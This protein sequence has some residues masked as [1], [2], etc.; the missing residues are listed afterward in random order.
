MRP[1]PA[2]VADA[3]ISN[4][5]D[6]EACIQQRIQKNQ[7]MKYINPFFALRQMPD[8]K[9]PS[10][11]GRKTRHNRS[12]KKSSVLLSSAIAGLSMVMISNH[13]QGQAIDLGS[14]EDF[15]IISYAGLTST[16]FSIVNGDV[17]LNPIVSLVGFPPGVINGTVYANASAS[18]VNIARIARLDAGTAYTTLAG[19]TGGTVML[20]AQELNGLTLTP[21]I[22]KFSTSAQLANGGT[23]NLDTGGDPN[24]RFIFQIGSALT[25]GTGAQIVFTSGATSNIYWQV[26]SL[27]TIDT[28]STFSGNILAYASVNIGTGSTLTD[29]RAIAL[30]ESVTLQSNTLSAP[31]M[32][33]VPPPGSGTGAF[34]NGSG[35]NLW[36]GATNWSPT[37]LGVAQNALGPDSNV[38]FSIEPVSPTAPPQNQNTIL[39]ADTT[40]RTLTVNDTE[41]VTIG[42]PLVG[43]PTTLTISSLDNV[44]AIRVNTGAGRVVLSSNFSMENLVQTITVNNEAGMLIS[45]SI[46]SD[47]GLIMAGTGVLTLTG[48]STYTGPTVVSSG[49]LQ[50]GDGMTV[51]TSIAASNS[52][53]VAAPLGGE[54]TILA[55]NLAD[56]ETFEN[57]VTNSGQIQWIQDGTNTQ[58]DTSVFSGI[59]SMAITGTGTTVLLGTNTFS[60]G[61]TID[62]IGDV[63]VGNSAAF[64]S[65]VLTINDG[66]IDTFN[67]QILQINVG[68]YQQSGGVINM[69]LAGTAN[70]TYT[71]FQVA[72]GIDPFDI[73]LS[74]GTVFV[75]D[76][77][78]AYVPHGGDEQNIIATTGTRTGEFS[79]N[80][81]FSQFYNSTFNEDFFYHEGDTLLYPTLTYDAQNVYVT[82]VQ[83]SF[84]SPLNLTPN[85]TSV[86]NNLDAI[87]DANPGAPGDVVDY[88]NGQAINALPA[89]Y[90]LIAP[91]ELTSIFKMGFAA[92][93]T[94][95]LN[96][97][98]HLALIRRGNEGSR[99]YTQHVSRTSDSKGGL[100]KQ[101]VMAPYDNSWGVFAEGTDTRGSVDS[102]YNASGYNYDMR[103]VTVGAARRT[104]DHFAFGV[105]GNY[106]SLDANLYNNGNIEGETYKGAI[107]ATYFRDG[108]FLDGLIGAGISSYDIQRASLLGTADGSTDGWQLDTMI[109]AGYDIRQGNWTITP[110]ASASYSRV[111]LNS[112]TETGSLSPL[113]YPTQNQNSLRSDLGVKI[114]YE[115][116]INNMVFTP[117]VRLSWQHE[118]MDSTQ[119]ID[120]QYA[121][122]IG[123][124]FT[125]DGP[126][127]NR[128][129][130]MISA[131]LNVQITPTI[132]AYIYYDG[133]LGS[134]D[135]DANSATLGLQFA[136]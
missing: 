118:F 9:L 104:S 135:S 121:S 127:M 58:A 101:S 131:G 34:W 45:G 130:A 108:F 73:D 124:M 89:M 38:V 75:Y 53:T 44:T 22:Y 21:G 107:Y 76:Q 12:S 16:G 11:T 60:G 59:G 92:A 26:G 7:N 81:P 8:S 29:G 106:S 28:G 116:V 10:L 1:M 100:L 132:D 48:V 43:G 102:T 46:A 55:I 49:T 74:G 32:P 85:Q 42:N 133:Q 19:L 117:Q 114:A 99:S 6:R 71:K 5:L 41:D 84:T 63:L 69:R 66:S 72:D 13:A 37:V 88:L 52:L 40:I 94:Q 70:G 112:F 39:D 77:S 14:A 96:I 128:D 126:E 17:A 134:S 90:D 65:G 91:D 35:S 80:S 111:T 31:A 120:S 62:T 23:L 122:G 50:L 64:G 86:A 56:G 113:S 3:F 47:A 61:T 4:S 27:A 20:P 57:S 67:S 15:T 95:N 119:S 109:N 129:R 79:S 30:N 97:K 78:G 87:V 105:L 115:A 2:T 54:E 25:V 33:V 98:R 83:D 136:F 36:S 93:E 103:G 68:G 125:V 18:D 110:M 123:P 51:G 82:W 24:A